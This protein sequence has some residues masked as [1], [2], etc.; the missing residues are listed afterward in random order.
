MARKP[1][2][3]NDDAE[4]V[5][6]QPE[7]TKSEVSAEADW[8][9]EDT[10]P[11]AMQRVSEEEA[12][13]FRAEQM[14]EAPPMRE[15]A[16]IAINPRGEFTVFTFRRTD[17]LPWIPEDGFVPGGPFPGYQQVS[18]VL[19]FVARYNFATQMWFDGRGEVP[20][21]LQGQLEN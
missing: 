17:S 9:P 5:A 10:E 13:N 20:E 2:N 11:V 3:Q 14:R 1:V 8:V 6:A 16:I 12:W 19:Q 21:A 18:R 7:D 4:P 15:D